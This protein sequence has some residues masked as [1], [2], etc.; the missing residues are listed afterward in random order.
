MKILNW[1]FGS[2]KPAPQPAP[3]QCHLCAATVTASVDDP[4]GTRLRLIEEARRD[5]FAGSN[6]GRND[7]LDGVGVRAGIC[8]KCERIYCRWCVRDYQRCCPECRKHLWQ[9]RTDPEPGEQSGSFA[10]MQ[11]VEAQIP[12]PSNPRP[13][14][15]D[16]DPF[17][18][19]SDLNPGETEFDRLVA[20]MGG[21]DLSR[22]KK[23]MQ[24]V[25]H[26]SEVGSRIGVQAL[27]AAVRNRNANR[28]CRF[29]V[30]G[31]PEP[32]TENP[33]KS[34]ALLRQLAEQGILLNNPAYSQALIGAALSTSG[35][36]GGTPPEKLIDE[37]EKAGGFDQGIA[38]RL[39]WMHRVAVDLLAG[40]N[41][42][43]PE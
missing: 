39:L 32:G 27:I 26:L 10:M 43:F 11:A 14:T 19:E 23:A 29:Y 42:I 9:Y 16:R 38:T 36:R 12:E 2:P 41:E 8:T 6:E 33:E 4:A 35:T 22:F 5:P 7:M 34:L 28:R 31:K 13:S 30:P 15:T 18:E 40:R 21:N 3:V 37:L 17:E 25:K 1:L 24:R 20:A